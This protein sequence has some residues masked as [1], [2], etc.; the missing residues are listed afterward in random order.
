M[1]FRQVGAARAFTLDQVRHGVEPHAV[2][3]LIEPEP[4]HPGHG[5]PHLR[6]VEVQVGLVVEEPV[7]VVRARDRIPGPVRSL[8]VA[9]DQPDAGVLLVVVAPDVVIALARPARR[10]PCRLKPRVLIRGVVDDQ[11][12]DDAQPARVGFAQELPE[13]LQR[14]VRLV[15][16]FIVPDVVAVV[17]QRRGVERL[18]P[19]AGDAER[20]DVVEFA[21]QPLK[22]TD[23]VVIAVEI[24]ADVDLVDDGVFVPMGGP[25]SVKA[26]ATDGSRLWKTRGAVVSREPV[27]FPQSRPVPF[28]I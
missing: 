15:D 27:S 2:N 26:P 24:A 21:R 18:Q 1:R 14:A 5:F 17:A 20:L 11:L 25:S 19:D 10:L 22:V 13:V 9:E 23:A 6:V 16:A 3:A 7:P 4:H 28:V 12:G 8:G